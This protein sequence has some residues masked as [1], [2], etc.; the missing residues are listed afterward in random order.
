MRYCRAYI[1]ENAAYLYAKEIESLLTEAKQAAQA[2]R[3]LRWDVLQ[4]EKERIRACYFQTPLAQM[5]RKAE[6]LF[7]VLQNAA[8]TIADL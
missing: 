8:Q 6:P 4:K 5:Q 1:Y 7:A 3:E 2:H